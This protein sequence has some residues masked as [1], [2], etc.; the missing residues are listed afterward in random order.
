M[1]HVIASARKRLATRDAPATPA[2][3]RRSGGGYGGAAAG[4]TPRAAEKT[5]GGGGGGEYYKTDEDEAGDVYCAF[6]VDGLRAGMAL[7]DATTGVLSCASA[8]CAPGEVSFIAETLRKQIARPTLVVLSSTVDEETRREMARA[9]GGGDETAGEG[10]AVP[11]T[12]VKHATFSLD[13]ARKLLAAIRLPGDDAAAASS[14]PV[15]RALASHID[16]SDAVLVRAAGAPAEPMTSAAP[17][18]HKAPLRRRLGG[19][20]AC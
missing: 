18:F 3:K 5:P 12:V 4:S 17:F 16:L 1:S 6:L 13:T 9:V 14:E 19:G 2:T 15:R 11:V 8:H 7:Y 20:E 10:S